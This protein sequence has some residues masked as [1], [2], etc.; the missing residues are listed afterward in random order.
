MLPSGVHLE[1]D[2]CARGLLYQSTST[3]K[4]TYV[5]EAWGAGQQ[6]V[7]DLDSNVGCFNLNPFA[8]W[9]VQGRAET[10]L[11]GGVVKFTRD[12]QLTGL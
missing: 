4:A 6:Q 10:V 2:V 3:L 8:S 1:G 12:A 5:P 7:R 9:R 11:V